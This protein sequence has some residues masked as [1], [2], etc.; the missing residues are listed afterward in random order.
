[1]ENPSKKKLG[2]ADLV[3][4]GIGNCIG[5]GIFVSLCVGME[6]TGRSITLAVVLAHI[7]VL[8]AYAYKTL[9]AG[10][11]ALPG[12]RYGQSVLLQPPILFGFGAVMLVF[13]G[14]AYSM[15]AL[16][17]V[18]YA[19][20]VFPVL[21]EY[22]TILAV[23][24]VTLFFLTTLMGAKFM[25]RF[26]LIMVVVLLISL[27]V[28][29]AAGIPQVDW[30]LVNP[31]SEGSFS[32]GVFGFI[33]AAA[34]LS[35]ACQGATLP[36]DM[37]G[38]TKDPKRSLPKS[39]LISSLVV[40]VFYVLIAIVT[41]GVLPMDQVAGKNLGVIA[42]AI[43]PRPVFV[44]FILGGACMAIATSLYG[45]LAG[46]PEPLLAAV[47]DGWLPKFLGKKTKKG[48]PWVIMLLLY[49]IT[50]LL[51]FFDFGLQEV[52]S[53]TMIP[54]MLLNTANN[55]LFLRLVKRY[56][57]AWKKSFFHMPYWLTVIVAVFAALC[58]LLITVSLLTTLTGSKQI[59]LLVLMVALVV[60]CVLR[61]KSGKV[62]L[63]K[64]E[65]FRAQLEQ[66]AEQEED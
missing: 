27:F 1:M 61:L 39:I 63:S 4:Y 44:L 11:F 41:A 22:K 24:I 5:S 10:M 47:D 51:L 66:E 65:T 37:T 19:A 32:G 40:L 54:T 50:I 57:T 3:C 28:Y 8:F 29:V 25:G 55:I 26:N 62:D 35:F 64:I 49:S 31:F 38:D 59:L 30:T 21:M 17:V 2:V 9:M 20:T 36:I 34:T 53:L 15:Y 48:Y 7:I 16:S 33:V 42:E 60:Y 58:S 13:G 56:P 45:S 23:G 52:I 18:E 12:G 43:F 46:A 6:N 14:F